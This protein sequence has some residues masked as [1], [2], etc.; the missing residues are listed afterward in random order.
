[1]GK[2][3][4][5]RKR[6]KAKRQ[7]RKE[8]KRNSE[9]DSVD[10]SVDEDAEES[11]VGEDAESEETEYGE[12]NEVYEEPCI[13]ESP[14]PEEDKDAIPVL[15]DIVHGLEN[16]QEESVSASPSHVE[17][18]DEKNVHCQ[19]EP[20]DTKVDVERH[21]AD[22]ARRAEQELSYERDTEE[23]CVVVEEEPH[24]GTTEVHE[25]CPKC[26]VR[27]IKL[28]ETTITRNGIRVPTTLVAPCKC[29]GYYGGIYPP[30][31]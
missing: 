8:Q 5:T 1:M 23:A 12:A 20:E 28:L 27:A 3:L 17:E 30:L 26:G 10:E 21:V 4:R 7:E 19:E 13:E 16:S 18:V 2:T 24:C 9:P 31:D 6:R 14:E 25:K 11:I 15:G 29:G 22:L